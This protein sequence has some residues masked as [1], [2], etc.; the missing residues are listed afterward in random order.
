MSRVMNEGVMMRCKEITA[1]FLTEV[2]LIIEPSTSIAKPKGSLKAYIYIIKTTWTL[3]YSNTV[4]SPPLS[5]FLIFSSML[6]FN[7]R[8]H[9]SIC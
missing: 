7:S 5:I 3:T 8:S 2:G 6:I 9:Q 4:K 1:N